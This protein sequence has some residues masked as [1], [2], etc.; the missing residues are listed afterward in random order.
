MARSETPPALSEH[1]RSN[2]PVIVR[3]GHRRKSARPG[4]SPS[5]E[6]SP[7][8]PMPHEMESDSTRENH[9]DSADSSRKAR[10][11]SS[12]RQDVKRIR[13]ESSRE[14]EVISDS[15][16]ACSDLGL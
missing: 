2:A 12:L 15:A 7:E 8:I 16:G 9:F 5:R 6:L 1:N 14:Y 3:Y 10:G 13:E 4:S 11:R